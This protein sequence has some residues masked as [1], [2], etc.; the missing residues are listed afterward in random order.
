MKLIDANKL[1]EAIIYRTGVAE[2][3]DELYDN[4]YEIIDNAP[5]VEVDNLIL[6]V[7]KRHGKRE[8]M[9]N[10]L[11]PT[12]KWIPHIGMNHQCSV[13]GAYFPLSEFRTRPFHVN[14]C[15]A[16]GAKMEELMK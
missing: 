11:R 15:I 14:Y 12:G 13:C 9:L 6:I 10:A 8:M 2:G 3:N 1:K 7:A 5:T 4:I 16:C